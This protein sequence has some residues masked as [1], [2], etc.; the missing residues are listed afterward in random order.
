MKCDNCKAD[1]KEVGKINRWIM[2]EFYWCPECGTFLTKEYHVK[3]PELIWYK[4]G[5][6][7]E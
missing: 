3:E 2:R 1:M 6:M 7:F 4:P 5:Y